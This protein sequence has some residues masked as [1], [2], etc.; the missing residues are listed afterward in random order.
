M[1]C[2]YAIHHLRKEA[3][4]Q[5]QVVAQLW[6]PSVD[7]Y[8]QAVRNDHIFFHWNAGS[9]KYIYIYIVFVTVTK[10]AV[11]DVSTLC[12]PIQIFCCKSKHSNIKNTG[13]PVLPQMK[14]LPN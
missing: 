9:V 6:V 2:S 13:M 8:L 5:A 14:S 10:S 1:P 11:V 7:A 3:E 4:R 12:R